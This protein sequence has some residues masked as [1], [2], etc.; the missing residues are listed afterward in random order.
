MPAM[1]AAGITGSQWM[2]GR[3]HVAVL[4]CGDRGW[5]VEELSAAVVVDDVRCRGS[6]GTEPFDD[7]RGTNHTAQC[8]SE[9]GV[10][11]W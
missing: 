5:D 1:L 10:L 6:A 8:L 9:H 11:R 2:K 4:R 3:R 7:Y